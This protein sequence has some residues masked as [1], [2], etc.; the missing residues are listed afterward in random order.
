MLSLFSFIR[1]RFEIQ[2][3]L[4][5]IGLIS[6]PYRF[7]ICSIYVRY[8][9][10]I[11][12]ISIQ[13]QF[14][15][16]LISVWYRFDID[17]I[18][19]WYRFDIDSINS[20]SVPYW[21]PWL[22]GGGTITGLYLQARGDF[23]DSEQVVINELFFTNHTWNFILH[24]KVSEAIL[25]KYAFA[26]NFH[27]YLSA[28]ARTWSKVRYFNQNWYGKMGE[29]GRIG[30]SSIV[31]FPLVRSENWQPNLSQVN[32]TP[33]APLV[34]YLVVETITPPDA[35]LKF[36]VTDEH[37]K[38]YTCRAC[39]VRSLFCGGENSHVEFQALSR[40]K[41]PWA[42]VKRATTDMLRK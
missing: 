11:G 40:P 17:S 10:D 22:G 1:Y 7:D 33:F 23:L 9:F 8:G 12:L 26:V 31:L 29:S 28:V 34:S 18:S 39:L 14:D 3:Q 25:K 24:S 21:S 16:H 2:Y 27:W 20:I 37:H 41:S 13:Y 6:L 38:T 5:D 19:V 15:F 35:L 30:E 32:T 36:W 42:E 4:S